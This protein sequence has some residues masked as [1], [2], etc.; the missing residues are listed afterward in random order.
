MSSTNHMDTA[1]TS[2]KDTS[3]VFREE[4]DVSGQV[5]KPIYLEVLDNNVSLTLNQRA[6][7]PC[8]AVQAS[9]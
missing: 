1:T 7:K 2:L 9:I 8:G 5:D 3:I 6:S 4:N